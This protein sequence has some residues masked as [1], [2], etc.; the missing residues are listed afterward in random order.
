MFHVPDDCR[1]IE[2]PYGSFPED[3]NNGM[4][5]IVMKKSINVDRRL[6]YLC[7]A[8]DGGGWEHVSVSLPWRCPTW[9]EMCAIKNIFWDPEDLVVQFHPPASEYVNNHP[10]CL[11]L[12]RK[13]GSNDFCE[14]PPAEFV[15]LK[16][17]R[18]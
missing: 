18:T 8:S 14:T 15:G 2:G 10:N 1:V 4:F 12:W 5:R 13:C 17:V 3:G 7:V 6:R 11:H 9:N 16:N